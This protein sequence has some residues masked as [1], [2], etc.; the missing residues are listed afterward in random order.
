MVWE[1]AHGPCP[2]PVEVGV[3]SLPSCRQRGWETLRQKGIPT[4]EAVPAASTA[5]CDVG[6]TSAPV[7]FMHL[8]I[9]G[10]F[11]LAVVSILIG[12]EFFHPHS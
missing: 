10:F 12:A 11:V 1:C 9:W 5:H 4:R 2:P 3:G 8:D 6:E 7:F